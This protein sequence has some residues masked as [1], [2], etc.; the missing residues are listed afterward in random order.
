M[1]AGLA[2]STTA[3]QVGVVVADAQ[4]LFLD[5]VARAISQHAALR[6]M[7]AVADG[8][9]ALSAIRRLQPEV[10]VVD[11]DLPGIDGRSMLDAIRLAGLATRV[12]LLS[13]A[14][15]AEATFGA[16][17][18]G[19]AGYLSKAV[20]RDELCRA[21]Q[22]A[23]IGES[24]FDAPVQTLVAREIRMRHRDERPLLSA[25]EHEILTLIAAGR[26]GPEICRALHLSSSTVKSHTAHLFEKLG[27][28]DRAS[29][30]AA[31]MRRGFLK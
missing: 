31:A 23:A 25:R 24:L 3:S 27:V 9:E 20:D 12:V 5:A 18:A 29:A 10:A 6:L 14:I 7:A 26:T 15:G 16:L 8:P 1:A 4:P 21:V 11:H 19:A 2:A 17:G 28:S 22:A 30:V 13:G